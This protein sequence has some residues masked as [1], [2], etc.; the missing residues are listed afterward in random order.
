MIINVKL[1]LCLILHL[2]YRHLV[3]SQPTWQPRLL[4]QLESK[5]TQADNRSVVTTV[6]LRW[7]VERYRFTETQQAHRPLR[8]ASRTTPPLRTPRGISTKSTSQNQTRELINHK[9]V[10]NALRSTSTQTHQYSI[11][12]KPQTDTL[13][14]HEI[15][16]VA[17]KV[18]LY[19]A[20]SLSFYQ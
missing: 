19:T 3:G 20:K 18:S 13:H 9:Y 11:Q 10:A 12:S 16:V 6:K 5:R 2:G 1:H 4:I 17:N 14:S 8:D 7:L 15:L